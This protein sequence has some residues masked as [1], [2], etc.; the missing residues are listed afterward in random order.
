M[1]QRSI[2]EKIMKVNVLHY[3]HNIYSVLKYFVIW[4]AVRYSIYKVNKKVIEVEEFNLVQ[5]D[6]SY[7]V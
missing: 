3:V 2:I 5:R 6:I 4:M 1:I 7:T